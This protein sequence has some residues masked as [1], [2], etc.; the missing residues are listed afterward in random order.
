MKGGEGEFVTAA[1]LDQLMYLE[2]DHG[3]DT[4]LFPEVNTVYSRQL[5]EKF[6]FSFPKLVSYSLT[7]G[8]ANGGPDLPFVLL[9]CN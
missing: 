4:P 1:V 9:F 6:H 2:G 3:L 5:G 8:M 7:S